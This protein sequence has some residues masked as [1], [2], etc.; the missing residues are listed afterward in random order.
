MVLTTT[1]LAVLAA[2][3]RVALADRQV[4]FI[5]KCP[6]PY[7]YWVVGP[8][9]SGLYVV[10]PVALIVSKTITSLRF[11]EAMSF[12]TMGAPTTCSLAMASL[13]PKL[14]FIDTNLSIV[15]PATRVISRF[16]Q[17]ALMPFT[18]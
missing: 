11:S 15:L 1:A 5:N 10:S 18:E 6:Y 13:T 8:A 3:L 14:D 16:L 7:Y 2:I 17:T 12:I 4:H 9:N